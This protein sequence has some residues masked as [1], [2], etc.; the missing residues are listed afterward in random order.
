[1]IHTSRAAFGAAAVEYDR[2]SRLFKPAAAF[3]FR[4]NITSIAGSYRYPEGMS[5]SEFESTLSYN[6]DIQ[7]CFRKPNECDFRVEQIADI[8]ADIV[9]DL[10]DDWAELQHLNPELDAVR[11]DADD[12]FYMLHAV[13]GA[14]CMLNVADIHFYI[15]E[16]K[17][18]NSQAVFKNLL[19]DPDYAASFNAVSQLALE[20]YVGWAPC[21]ETLEDIM[22]GF[23][24]R[25]L[26]I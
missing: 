17:R 18:S 6:R 25:D 2:A 8:P 16:I 10:Q 1:M 21:P 11:L 7:A 9:Q 15:H 4:N 12:H 23:A 14:A 24:R 3:E 26:K 19:A 22:S 13:N 5:A 20:Q